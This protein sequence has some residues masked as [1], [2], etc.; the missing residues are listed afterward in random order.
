[1]PSPRTDGT[2]LSARVNDLE[3]KPVNNQTGTAYTL[4]LTDQGAVV[5]V[6]NASAAT[7]TVPSNASVA[8]PIGATINLVRLGAGTVVVAPAGGVTV[9]AVGL[10]LNGQYAGGTLHK[11]ATD[12]W[13]LTGTLV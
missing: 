1:M 4:A 2:A 12:T 6:N 7:V 3:A 9:R 10:G 5:T 8:F 11:I 13:S